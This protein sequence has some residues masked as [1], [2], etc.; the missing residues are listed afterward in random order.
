M[1]IICRLFL[2]LIQIKSRFE[3]GENYLYEFFQ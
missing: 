1:D 3:N 2:N